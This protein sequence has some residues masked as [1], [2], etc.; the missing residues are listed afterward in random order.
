MA[1]ISKWMRLCLA[2]SFLAV[3]AALLSAPAGA[4]EWKPLTPNVTLKKGDRVRI[5][6]HGE[7]VEGTVAEPTDRWGRTKVEFPDPR[8]KRPRSWSYSPHQIQIPAKRRSRSGAA[9]S[10]GAASGGTGNPFQPVDA[11][12]QWTDD[13][14]KFSIEAKLVEVQGANAL[15]EKRDG[16]RMTV[17]IARLCES[18]RK[19]LAERGGGGSEGA[20]G[21][22]PAEGSGAG[23]PPTSSE[24]PVEAD[25]SSVD[26]PMFGGVGKPSNLEPDGAAEAEEISERPV[27]LPPEGS[28]FEKID[29]IIPLAAEPNV[30]VVG[31]HADSDQ[32]YSGIFECTLGKGKAKIK[33]VEIPDASSVLDVGPKGNLLLTQSDGFKSNDKIGLNFWRIDGTRCT[34]EWTCYPYLGRKDVSQP[35]IKW[36]RF[37]DADHAL[38]CSGGGDLVLWRLPE[39]K[40]VYY[41]KN[42][43]MSEAVLSSGRKYLA[44]VRDTNLFVV[45]AKSG[46]PL[47][48]YPGAAG[49][50][51]VLFRPD[52]K[53]IALIGREQVQVWEFS[54]GEMFRDITFSLP[55]MAADQSSWPSHGYLLLGGRYLADLERHTVLW[56]YSILAQSTLR[57]ANVGRMFWV[58]CKQQK[59]RALIPFT[60]PHDEVK[61]ALSQIKA[62]DTLVLQPGIDVSLDIQING[63]PEEQKTIR[64]DFQ[65]ILTDT[66]FRVGEGAP[67]RFVLRTEPAKVEETE[68]SK[69]RGIMHFGGEKETVHFQRWTSRVTIVIDGEEVWQK[70]TT[71]HAP[72]SVHLEEGETASSAVQKY[73]KPDLEFFKKV[74]PPRY[75]C[76]PRK[77][78]TFGATEI[79]PNGLKRVDPKPRK[80]PNK[81]PGMP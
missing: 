13:T 6:H 62:E 10:G 51:T 1:V 55:H 35:A 4:E 45:D 36:A 58:L 8:T 21:E 33:S 26:K 19:Y 81:L 27:M 9:A 28:H 50:G 61:Q 77:T 29:A 63:T 65:R 7:W 2:V 75:L 37:L 24:T 52:G 3:F 23:A 22:A 11:F 20:A 72:G 60:M 15:L 12:R 43:W 44:M 59:Q 74:R 14:G 80:D 78:L 5:N 31:V 73:Q 68:Y 41:V 25:W 46:K 39:M 30:V 69:G 56:E 71:T 18:D 40:A 34:K 57:T 64:E 54:N 76:L 38:T 17:P 66:G 49:S 32:K 47:G 53:R 79:T 42:D 70:S 67:V 48:T 16:G